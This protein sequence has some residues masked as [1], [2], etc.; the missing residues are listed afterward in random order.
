MSGT[1]VLDTKPL[2]IVPDPDVKFAA[3]ESERY[4]TIVDDLHSLQRRGVAVATALNA[5]HPQMADAATKVSGNSAI[6]ASVKSQFESLNKE[7]EAIR[8]KFGVPTNAPPADGRGGG[9]GGGGAGG[10]GG[11]RGGGFDPENV[12]GRTS[13]LKN[14]LA[15]IWEVPSASMTRQYTELKLALPKAITDANALLVKAAAVSQALK[16]YDIT[17]TVPSAP[18]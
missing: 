10:R 18:K 2:K 3:G 16:K 17:L 7:Y 6:P 13:A 12:L 14:A 9:G 15:G 8:K 4:N 11:G 5:L 1:K